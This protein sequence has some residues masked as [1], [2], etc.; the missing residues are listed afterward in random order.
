MHQEQSQDF[1]QSIIQ[2]QLRLILSD[3]PTK[4]NEHFSPL[5]TVRPYYTL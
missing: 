1:L 2:Q 4:S 3:A 5:T